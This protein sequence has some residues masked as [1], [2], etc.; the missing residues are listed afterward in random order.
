M[1]PARGNH[2]ASGSLF[3]EV[4]AFPGGDRDSY[5]V[6]ALSP[7][8]AFIV[9]NSNASLAGDQKD[10]LEDTL[11]QRVLDTRWILAS[12]HGPAY[13]AVKSPGEALEHWVPLFERFDVDLVCESDGHALKRT[14]PMRGGEGRRRMGSSMW[15]KGGS[16]LINA[17]LR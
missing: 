3:G 11:R 4:F 5:Y 12:Y 9:L 14:R 17:V 10:F 13:P 2:E 6:S 7:D 1:V 16:E 15:G 8:V